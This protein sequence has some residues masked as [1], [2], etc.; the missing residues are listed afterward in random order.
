M[1]L[2][3]AT[4]L[5][6]VLNRKKEGSLPP[7]TDLQVRPSLSVGTRRAGD[8]SPKKAF[9]LLARWQGCELTL[10]QMN[11]L[12]EPLK[13]SNLISTLPCVVQDCSV[14]R[15]TSIQSVHLR[16]GWVH[17]LCLSK[18]RNAA[19]WLQSPELAV[20][21]SSDSRRRTDSAGSLAV[22]VVQLSVIFYSVQN[23]SQEAGVCSVC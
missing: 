19:L 4:L 23:S 3:S 11:G 20:P 1:E 2:D 6:W 13:L 5:G 21:R 18:G 12:L 14:L 16:R 15:L 9:L 7:T 17:P 10:S 22:C 8:W